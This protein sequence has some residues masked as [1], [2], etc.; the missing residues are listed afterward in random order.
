MDK[1]FIRGRRWKEHYENPASSTVNIG[2]FKE[3]GQ[4]EKRDEEK[5]IRKIVRNSSHFYST[6]PNNYDIIAIV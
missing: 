3:V 2:F 6:L 5:P 4:E 1:Q